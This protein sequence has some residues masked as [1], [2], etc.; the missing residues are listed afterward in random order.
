V[1]LTLE[2]LAEELGWGSSGHNRR[3]VAA[4]LDALRLASFRARVYHARRGELRTTTFGLVDRWE[5]GI[6]KRA[7]HSAAAGFAVL[8]DW[9]HEQLRAGF[10]SYVDW[11]ELRAIHRPRQAPAPLPRGG[12]LPPQRPLVAHDRRRAAREPRHRGP[13]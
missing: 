8:G 7:G 3:E 5:A 10:V 9:L 2:G 1:A 11:R 13:A 12:A 4:A 6:A